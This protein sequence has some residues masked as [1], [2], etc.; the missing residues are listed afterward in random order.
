M[1]VIY[2]RAYAGM[3]PRQAPELLSPGE[4]TYVLNARLDGSDIEPW[5]QPSTILALTAGSPIKTI[6]RFGQDLASET[7]YWFQFTTDV[8][9]VKG[10]INDDTEERTYWTGDGYP[11]KTKAS[12]ATGG[13]PYPYSSLRMGLPQ[14]SYTPVVTVNGTAT[15][16]NDPATSVLYKVVYVSSWGE[17]GKPS[18][19]SN[20][21]TYRPGQTPRVTLP[22]A[23]SGAYDITKVWVYRSNTGTSSTQY[24]FAA[25][26]NVGTAYWD[27][28]VASS[29]LGAVMVSANFD[30]PDDSMVGLTSVA[31]EVMA[32]FFGNQLCYSEPGYP[33]AWPIKYRQSLDAPIV[34]IASFDQT[35]VVST[36]KSITLFTGIDPANVTAT[37]LAD[38]RVCVSKRSMIEAFGGVVYASAVGLMLIDNSGIRDLTE[39]LMAR[40]DWQ[41]YK[42]ESMQTFAVDNRLIVS[43]DT[44]TRQGCLILSMGQDA[45]MAELSIV[46]TGGFVDRRNDELYLVVNNTIVKWNGGAPYTATWRSGV[47]WLPVRSCMRSARVDADVYPVRFSLYADGARVFTTYVYDNAPFRLPSG[48]RAHRFYY[49]I[50]TTGRVSSSGMATSTAE[51]MNGAA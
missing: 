27:D 2:H 42:P 5:N 38:T 37:K 9:V 33:Y 1:T 47:T 25:E 50:Q 26:L 39:T 16:P 34:A 20:I 3:R 23:P 10:P 32:G 51:L 11:K 36:K 7:Q 13:T 4:A 40:K 15:N 21:A 49:E 44:G 18:A 12:L 22:P 8:N 6:Y 46:P 19:A 41:A 17:A 30:A 24:Q 31:N 45:N 14:P 43:F 28:T 48:Y 29:A 35:T